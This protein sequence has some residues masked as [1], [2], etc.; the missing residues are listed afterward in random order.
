MNEMAERERF[1][2]VWKQADEQLAQRFHVPGYRG[3][4]PFFI[5]GKDLDLL[6]DSESVELN[7]RQLLEGILYGLREFDHDPKPWHSKED[8]HTLTNLLDVLMNGFNAETPEKLILD[9]ASIVRERNGNGASRTI[10]LNGIDL[11]PFSSKIRSDLICDTWAVAADA[12][13]LDL[14][15]PIPEWVREATLTELIPQAAEVICYYGLC[16]VVMLEDEEEIEGFIT[17][18]VYPNVENRKLKVKI[19]NL[20]ESPRSHSIIDL[21]LSDRAS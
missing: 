2:I 13:D 4:L 12:N 16:A 6:E 7:E 5:T 17:E 8:R 20:L 15:K 10:L 19:K 11:V 3:F 1:S 9:S 14:L 18:F 21:T